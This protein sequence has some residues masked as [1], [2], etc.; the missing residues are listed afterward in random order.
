MHTKSKWAPADLEL[1]DSGKQPEKLQGFSDL[2]TGL[3]LLTHSMKGYFYLRNGRLGRYS[4]WHDQ[5]QLTSGSAVNAEFKLL[6]NPGLVKSGD[7]SN[8]H[9]VLIQKST[10]FTIYLPPRLIK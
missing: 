3:L 9:S 10:N 8:I 4:I 5:L 7:T 1:H 2:E 6:D